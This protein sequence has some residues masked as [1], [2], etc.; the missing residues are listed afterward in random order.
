MFETVKN[1]TI[2]CRIEN[3]KRNDL[4]D[5]QNE[6]EKN[7]HSVQKL[8]S[9][10]SARQKE[11]K[12]SVKWKDGVIK[13][14]WLATSFISSYWCLRGREFSL[15]IRKFIKRQKRTKLAPVLKE[16]KIFFLKEV[17]TREKD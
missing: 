13:S 1:T 17:K 4:K 10:F 11:K 6:R 7:S 2:K 16:V 15:F 12:I 5:K 14:F 3:Q 8:I 9:D